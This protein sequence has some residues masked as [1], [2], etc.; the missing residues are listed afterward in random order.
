MAIKNK[1]YYNPR[2]IKYK[3]YWRKVDLSYIELINIFFLIEAR[4]KLSNSSSTK[5]HIFFVI[6]ALWFIYK[7]MQSIRHT[8]K[9]KRSTCHESW[10]WLFWKNY[11]YYF[12][13]TV[14]AYLWYST[15]HNRKWRKKNVHFKARS[16]Y[17][18]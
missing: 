16:F 17:I 13:E 11:V 5:F 6:L 1:I 2:H 14:S 18:H 12:N 10:W 8:Q 9:K 7:F 3:Y 15:T 4:S